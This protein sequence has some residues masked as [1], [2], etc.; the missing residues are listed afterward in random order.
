MAETESLQYP[1]RYPVGR[2]K[3][4]ASYG[5]GERKEQLAERKEQIETLRRLPDTRSRTTAG[6]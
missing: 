1:L 2:F 6:L 4:A 5:P 3:A